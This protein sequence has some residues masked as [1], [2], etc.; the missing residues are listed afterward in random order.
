MGKELLVRSVKD[1]DLQKL[2]S[3]HRDAFE[4]YM[5]TKLGVEYIIEFLKWFTLQQDAISLLVESDEKIHG[6][7]VGATIGY[8]SRLT[9]AIGK[10]VIKYLIF[11][12]WLLTNKKILNNLLSRIKNIFKP[13]SQPN[14]TL[15][16]LKGISLVG[17]GVSKSSRGHHYGSHLIKSFEKKAQEMKFD[18]MRL[19]VYSNNTTAISFYKKNEW[20]FMDEEAGL[21]YFY[22]KLF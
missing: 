11:H 4:G 16:D 12:P 3:I 5:N 20:E 19:S 13:T 21:S 6:Y 1:D 2:L 15:K 18:Y 22:K 10:T 9:K 17:I 14:I 7:V 8:G